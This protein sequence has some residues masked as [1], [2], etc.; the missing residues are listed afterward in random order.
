MTHIN[1]VRSLFDKSA[2]LQSKR[3]ILNG[4]DL[5]IAAVVAC[6]RHGAKVEISKDP[7]VLQRLED[8]LNL[9]KSKA[10]KLLA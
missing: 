9:L 8:S 1:L 10:G 3:T 6:A 7:A 4:H 2:T 5:D